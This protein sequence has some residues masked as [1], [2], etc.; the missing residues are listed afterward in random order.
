M[1]LPIISP[2]SPSE[3]MPDRL[4]PVP[5]SARSQV[6]ITPGRSPT[7]S[8]KNL[9]P[10]SSPSKEE[11]A[12]SPSE[13]KDKSMKQTEEATDTHE[14]VADER[15]DGTQMTK[16]PLPARKPVL[17]EKPTVAEKPIVLPKP[18]LL[19]KPDSPMVFGML[20]AC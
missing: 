20:C 9:S 14:K 12:K 2:P 13:D 4:S 10:V 8:P 5:E 6:A 16:P 11:K 18:R 15:T 7:S 19:P 1:A 3:V 17:T